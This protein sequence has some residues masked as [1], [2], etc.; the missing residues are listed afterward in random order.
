MPPVPPRPPR[1]WSTS[2]PAKSSTR[3]A[4]LTRSSLVGLVSSAVPASRLFE[5]IV[6]L[7]QCPNLGLPESPVSTRGPNAADPARGRPPRHGLRI[8]S[9]QRGDLARCQQTI[10]RLHGP[11]LSPECSPDAALPRA[12]VP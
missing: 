12:A 8:D 7:E 3:R 6:A 11:L 5:G 2:S 10:S 1:S 9:K 4:L